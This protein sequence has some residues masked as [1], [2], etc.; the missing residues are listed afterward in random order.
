MASRAAVWQLPVNV[1]STMEVSLAELAARV[2]PCGAVGRYLYEELE[3]Y[4]L[5][6]DEAWDL[7]R[8]ENW[9]LG[10]S[11]VVGAL[12]GCGWRGNFHTETAPLIADDMR[13]L[14]NPGGKEIRVYDYVDVRFILEDLYAKLALC[15][16]A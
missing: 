16:M 2:R 9:C 15:G 4:N 5:H 3:D 10:D 12:L 14:P 6:S 7:R 8:G 13:Y 11:P 1:Y